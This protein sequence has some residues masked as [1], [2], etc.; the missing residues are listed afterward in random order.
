VSAGTTARSIP[1]KCLSKAM[2]SVQITPQ[3]AINPSVVTG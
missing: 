1:N 3:R 2:S